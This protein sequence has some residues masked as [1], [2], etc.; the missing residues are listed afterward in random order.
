MKVNTPLTPSVPEL[1]ISQRCYDPLGFT[2]QNGSF[3]SEAS[4]PDVSSS[5]G[6][7]SFVLILFEISAKGTARRGVTFLYLSLS[8]ASPMNTDRSSFRAITLK[9]L[10][11]GRK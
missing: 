7:F 8:A 1:H 9:N 11:E 4:Q 3:Y 2:A 6:S 5:R 10:Q